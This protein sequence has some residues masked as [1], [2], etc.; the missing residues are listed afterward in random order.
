V[1]DKPVRMKEAVT[2]HHEVY[3]RNAWHYR[4]ELQRISWSWDSSVGAENR[5]WGGQ[6]RSFNSILN[7]ERIFSSLWWPYWLYA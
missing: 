1:N 4:E 3:P 5:L 2:V 6:I 7:R